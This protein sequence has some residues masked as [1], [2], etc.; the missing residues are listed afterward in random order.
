MEKQK[1]KRNTIAIGIIIFFCALL[2]I[3]FGITMYFT[4]HFYFGSTINCV[5]VSGK[6][7]EEVDEQM[8][9]EVKEYTLELQERG[10]TKEQI[11][12]SDIGLEYKLEGKVKELK[13][14]QNSFAWIN[15]PFD[16]TDYKIE[17]VLTLTYDEKLFKE[18]LNK[19]SCL[20]SSNIIEPQ[21]PR[22]KYIDNRY[23]ILDEVSGNKIN[24]DILYNSVINAILKGEKTIDLEASNC[25]EN[26]QYNSNSQEVID[27]RDMLN[28]YA[29]SQITY[30][31]GEKKEVLDGAIINTWLKTNENL[32][33]TFD[34]KEIRSY[35]DKLFDNYDTVGKS[36]D[37][38]TSGGTTIK[39]S[40]G[41]YGWLINR[42]QEIQDLI[43][44]IKGGQT[45]TKEPIYVQTALSH[46][47][48]DIGNTYVEINM[49]KQYL[50]FYKNGVLLAEGAVVTGNISNNH[51]TPTGIYKLKYKQ[52][53][54]TLKGEGYSTHV[55]YWMPFNG[56]IGLHDASWRSEFGG[57]IYRTNGSHGCVNAP[58]Y[59][60]NKIFD[61][62]ESG[63]PVICYY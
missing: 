55:D 38:L 32:E 57:N 21:N 6:T 33:I 26:S 51:S 39:V 54:A 47:N 23:V 63:I 49:A 14:K 15:F 28:K 53:D 3:Y 50:W 40:G 31:F 25:Y 42:D 29:D 24:K 56:G 59:L 11:M 4:N 22:F 46:V 9:S 60:A 12:A 35:L 41:D 5:N 19:L 48:N 45:I 36:R 37:F 43:T 10:N 13:D 2:A 16:K 62:I 7:V 58:Y 34:E 17:E 8:I 61:N 20:D 30:T 52:K 27:T 18:C 44:I 1:N